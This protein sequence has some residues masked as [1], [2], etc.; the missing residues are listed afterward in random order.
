MLDEEALKREVWDFIQA[1]NRTWTEEGRPDRL[2][3]Y[4][5]ETMVAIT[6]TERERLRGRQA[7]VAGWKGFADAV[8]IQSWK[9]SDPDIIVYGSG[10]FA[11]FTCYWEISYTL[12]GQVFNTSGRDM[13]ALIKENG[14][15]WVVADQFSNY[16][17]Q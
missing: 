14:R 1:M 6:P 10:L 16:P 13:Y 2:S 9:V 12:D 11:I 8:T 7:C 15:W 4:F 5:H 3:E 17:G